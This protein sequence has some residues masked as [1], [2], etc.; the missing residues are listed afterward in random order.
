[1]K[2]FL[3]SGVA[4]AALTC[5]S[6]VANAQ[7]A[8]ILQD[9]TFFDL[10]TVTV[11]LTTHLTSAGYTVTNGTSLPGSLAGYKEVWDVEF[12]NT[13]ITPAVQSAYLAYL[14]AGGTLF[15]QGEN[16][17][18][19]TRNQSLVSFLN[20]AGA[21]TTVVSLTQNSLNAQTTQ[22]T[23]ATTPNAVPTVTYAAAAGFTSV[24]HGF[25]I[26]KD[27]NGACGAIGFPVNSLS[28]AKPGTIVVVLDVNFLTTGVGANPLFVDNL[29]AF[30]A[31]GGAGNVFLIPTTG[32]NINQTNVAT[33]INSFVNGG[34]TLPAGF[35]ALLTLT[36]AQ[37]ATA[38]TQLSGEPAT[39]AQQGAFELMNAFLGLMTDPFVDGR[40]GP[41]AR[42]GFTTENEPMAPEL[43]AAYA[44]VYKAPP[45]AVLTQHWNT[46]A[47]AYGGSNNTKGD[48][49][50]VGSNNLR[51][52]AGGFAAGAD[53]RFTPS[54]LI[55][56]A[57]GGGGTSWNLA[58]GL[59]SGR[60]DAFQAGIYGKTNWGPTYVAAS[61]AV[62]QHWMSTNRV[63]FAADQL[64]AKF[65][66]QS[67]G[68][69]IEGGYRIA[70][71][72]VAVTPYGAIQ[73]QSFRT[74]TYSETDLGGGGF[75]L[76]YTSRT[77]TD[78][79]GE[80]GARF[81]RSMAASPMSVLTLRGK[82]AYA[83]DWVSDASLAAVFQAL[84]G[85]AFI[86]NGAKP[87]HDSALASA[88]AELSFANGISLMAKFDGEFAAHSQT[89]AGTATA[90]FT[91]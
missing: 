23:V 83:H 31:N 9:G 58:Q 74:G 11:P 33:A 21:G 37:L 81:D 14:Q 30:L 18:F 17:G 87:A 1:M 85:N 43:A 76:N 22:G 5:V 46:W 62:A 10:N 3:L 13:L 55:G 65:N 20:A 15:L 60:S 27:A 53:Y 45:P 69:R 84:P 8:F 57:L 91:W 36:P 49:T 68:G 79:R 48:P 71:P 35:Q 6:S 44:A 19:D 40:G 2:K 73:A 88:G 86:V 54:T 34:G 82:V 16:T 32:L 7:N 63:A 70:N 59:G 38:L 47:S 25:C 61:F 28:N 67:Y 12:N 77:A 78:T 75:G 24:G 42:M 72:I 4:L 52:N 90:R 41:S 89:Y 56:F 50:V 29:I 39:G 66:G 51:A 26:T 64:S 80:V